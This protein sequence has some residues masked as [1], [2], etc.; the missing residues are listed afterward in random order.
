MFL[1]CDISSEL[2]MSHMGKSSLEHW[3]VAL[4][5]FGEGWHNNHHAFEYS[6]RHGLEWWQ[7]DICWYLIRLLEAV[8]LATNVKLPS[9]GHKH[10]KSFASDHNNAC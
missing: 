2:S 4:L 8:G 1:S 6:A 9:E 7:I 10:K 3:L 5:G